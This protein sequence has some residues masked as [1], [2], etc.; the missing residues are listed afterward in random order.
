MKE[1][2]D[3]LSNQGDADL[4]TGALLRQRLFRSLDRANYK[5]ADQRDS[6]RISV[7]LSNSDFLPVNNKPSKQKVS[8]NTVC[9][10]L[11]QG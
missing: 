7:G 5:K 2:N 9:N 8:Q 10:L 6:D 1:L 3:S 11:E 4:H